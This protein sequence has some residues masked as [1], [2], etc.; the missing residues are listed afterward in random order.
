MAR[1]KVFSLFKLNR[2]ENIFPSISIIGR[3][4]DLFIE[5]QTYDL[6]IPYSNNDYRVIDIFEETILRVLNYKSCESEE[7]S[8]LICLPL[9]L[10]NLILIRLKENGYLNENFKLTDKAY[11]VLN[12]QNNAKQK[13]KYTTGK[14]FVI[15]KT[16]YILPYIHIGKFITENVV[17]TSSSTFVLGYGTPGKPINVKGDYIRSNVEQGVRLNQNDYNKALK[18]FNKLLAAKGQKTIKRNDYAIEV[19]SSENIYFHFKVAIQDGNIDDLIFSDGFLVNVDGIA[20]YIDLLKT[21]EINNNDESSR[22]TKQIANLKRGATT[23]GNQRFEENQETDELELVELENETENK[24]YV[25]AE[26]LSKK[27][28]FYKSKRY[29]EVIK[30]YNS[31]EKTISTKPEDDGNIDD[32]KNYNTKKREIIKDCFAM[33]E[34]ALYFNTMK[35]SSLSN[36]IDVLNKQNRTLNSNLLL[37]IAEHLD[38]KNLKK[39]AYLFD[40]VDKNSISNVYQKNVPKLNVCLS[41]AVVQAKESSSTEFNNL[42]NEY[43][44]FLKF[45]SYLNS[46]AAELRHDANKDATDL[47]EVEIFENSAQIIKLLLPDIELIGFKSNFADESS[48]KRLFEQIYIERLLGSLYFNTLNEDIKKEWYKIAP[49]KSGRDLPEPMAY[50]SILSRLL[51]NAL[52]EAISQISNF[53]SCSKKDALALIKNK[54]SIDLPKGITNVNEGNVINAMS[55]SK[56]TLGAYTIAFLYNIESASLDNNSILDDLTKNNFI[57]LIQDISYLRKHDNNIALSVDEDKLCSL[58]QQTVNITKI[59]GDYYE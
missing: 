25:I 54:V 2:F 27:R 21:E 9:D 5:C 22:I 30:Y 35:N 39:N 57:E 48:R 51:E 26:N 40:N 37:K 17:E 53:K 14:I 8:E 24:T 50:I 55:K 52:F 28:D 13:L 45:L 3:T 33:I 18:N 56:S 19:S 16:G 59:L 41:Y 34:W 23:Y 1:Q 49:Y 31:I 6:M 46:K 38:I 10:V 44:D 4:V 12:T 58:R 20:K 29:Y 11:E 43:P 47:D 15:K 36:I 32:F 42:I 7:I